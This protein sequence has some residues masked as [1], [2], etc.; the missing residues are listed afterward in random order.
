MEN[1]CHELVGAF[2]TNTQPGRQRSDADPD[3]CLSD[4]R[5]HMLERADHATTNNPCK[6]CSK[7]YR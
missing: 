3:V 4:V 2:K 5:R 1:L 6:V 7:K